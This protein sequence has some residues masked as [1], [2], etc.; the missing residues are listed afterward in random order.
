M[1][2]I[3]PEK[4]DEPER[5]TPQIT[6]TASGTA[7]QGCAAPAPAATQPAV[8]A[9][10]RRGR[11]VALTELLTPPNVPLVL[12]TGGY[13][14]AGCVSWTDGAG[15]ASRPNPARSFFDASRSETQQ[16]P[17][18]QAPLSPRAAA[19]SLRALP[20]VRQRQAP[21]LR[22]RQLRLRQPEAGP[23]N[24]AGAGVRAAKGGASRASSGGRHGRG[25][26]PRRYP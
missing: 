12:R 4:N 2:T 13:R 8:P 14:P 16:E 21:A 25:S 22:L 3:L 24:G 15:L 7:V 5:T 11:G 18:A 26:R 1:G 19:D 23:A 20:P 17:Q 6:T 9:E 10:H